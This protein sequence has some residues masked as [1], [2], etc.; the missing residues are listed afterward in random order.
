MNKILNIPNCLTLIRL[1]L[2]PI[3]ILMHA[4][5]GPLGK[6]IAILLL[7]FSFLTDLADGKLARRL[8][9]VTRFGELF[10]PITDFTFVAGFNTYVFFTLDEIFSPVAT[11]ALRAGIV[12]ILLRYAFVATVVNRTEK[13]K[14]GEGRVIFIGK[15][16]S[17]LQMLVLVFF[18]TITSVESGEWR[19]LVT[20]LFT[21]S[22]LAGIVLATISAAKYFQRHNHIKTIARTVS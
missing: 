19:N 4:L 12:Y 13:L 8:G 18:M 17:A 14:K 21:I 2:T 7:I 15:C 10:D 20:L 22:F 6:L 11:L 5:L 1:L 16:S 9:Q 3:I